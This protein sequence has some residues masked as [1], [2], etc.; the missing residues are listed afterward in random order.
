MV[1]RVKKSLDEKKLRKLWAS[2]MVAKLI[3]KELGVS[4]SVV[5]M[6]RVELGLP[7]R[8]DLIAPSI[9]TTLFLHSEHIDFLHAEA[10]RRGMPP[11]RVVRDLI[12]KQ[13]EGQI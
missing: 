13:M 12:D 4:R 11:S 5:N 3:A 10:H 9:K 6:R 2:G 1:N 8:R 7:A